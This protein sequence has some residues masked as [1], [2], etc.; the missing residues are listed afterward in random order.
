MHVDRDDR[1][2]G[3]FEES[4]P[5][6]GRDGTLAARM[7]GTAAEGNARAKSGTLANVRSLA[8]Y[9]TSADGEPLVFAIVANNFGTMPEVAID[10]HRLDCRQARGIQTVR[11]RPTARCHVCEALERWRDVFDRH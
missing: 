1:M 5:I 8:G 7:K 4:L 6:A 9:V 2:R 3:P 10:R 11:E